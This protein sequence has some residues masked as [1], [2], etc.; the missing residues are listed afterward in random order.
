MSE[1]PTGSPIRTMLAA[2]ATFVIAALLSFAAGEILARAY[3]AWSRPSAGPVTKGDYM[4]YDPEFGWKLSPGTHGGY[5]S[6]EFEVSFSINQAGLRESRELAPKAPGTGRIL[7]VGDSFTFGFG[8]ADEDRFGDRLDRR[9]P[10]VDV[11]N[12]G[13][14]GTGTGQQLLLYER[15]G[16]RFDADV[17]VLGY[18]TE[19]ILRNAH[20]GRVATGGRMIPKPAFELRDDGELVLTN[21][22]V[23]REIMK[24]SPVAREWE[25]RNS[26]GVPIPFKGLLQRH[27]QLYILLRDRLKG[28]LYA[29]LETNAVPFPQYEKG[30]REWELTKALIR[31]LRDRVHENGSEFLL[32]LIPNR[33]YVVRDYVEDLPEQLLVSFARREGIDVVDLLPALERAARD[34]GEPYFRT[35]PH[36]TPEGH[37]VAAE[38]LADHLRHHHARLVQPGRHAERSS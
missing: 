15:V 11:W 24:Q 32:V 23:P 16:A 2:G 14:P 37:A 19:H 20:R 4:D 34:G 18:F 9:F 31:R 33:E 7:L 28:L 27:S 35:D 17:V 13:V 3:Y 30:R 26:A 29:R 1:S 8:V 25:E 12:L 22:P 38:V 5:R 6:L 21:V 36:W 10:A